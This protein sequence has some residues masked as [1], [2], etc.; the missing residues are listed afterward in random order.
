MSEIQDAAFTDV[1]PAAP[2]AEASAGKGMVEI[3]TFGEPESV[4][5]RRS[6]LGLDHMECWRNGRWYEP[7]ISLEGLSRS[8]N[9][10]PHHRSALQLKANLLAQAF[11]PH[12]LLDRTTFKAWALDFLTLANGYLE[13]TEAVTHRPLKLE[14]VPAKY[15][16]RG[17]D[18]EEY[19]FLT[20][21]LPGGMY[22]EEKL[23][24]RVFH[25]LEPD[26]DQEIYGTPEYVAALQAA[27]LNEAATVFRRRYYK[28]GSHA[29]FILYSTDAQL[30]ADDVDK[31]R[32]A[33]KEAK[34]PGNF[35]N[36]F[37][38][39]PGGKKDGM[40]LI[41]VSEVAAKDEFM[42]IK[43]TSRDDVLAAHRVPP[44]L[45]GVIPANTGGFGKAAEAADVF[46]RLEMLPLRSTF[47][48]L[49]DWL[50][51]EVVAFEAWEPL[52]TPGAA[53]DDDGGQ[54]GG[55]RAS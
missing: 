43:N 16:R 53:S 3:F 45:L 38:H 33:L 2:V 15:T 41:P 32:G 55:M 28:N 5:D 21:G 14:R 48:A 46:H 47:L 9:A 13:L 10:S 37:L 36:L 8:R 22:G 18:L 35:R 23:G 24:K 19:Y 30:E 29:G 44:Q 27:W 39:A 11:I 50:G 12:R 25:L 26:L 31:L 20:Q 1:A 17:V 6:L 7:P 52:A 4:L 34:G 54:G 40:Q 49:N 51:E 42:S